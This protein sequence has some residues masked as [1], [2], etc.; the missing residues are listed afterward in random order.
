MLVLSRREN[1][2]IVFPALG[3][4]VEVMKIGRTRASIGIRAP[5]GI[6]VLRHELAGENEHRPSSDALVESIRQRIALEFEDQIAAAAEKLQTAQ[7]D[8]AA[9]NTERA[10]AILGQAITDLTPLRHETQSDR[11]ESKE[12]A[13]EKPAGPLAMRKRNVKSKAETV[14]E[15]SA[16]YTTSVV[17]DDRAAK[18]IHTSGNHTVRK[19]WVLL[20]APS[21]E[22]R[23]VSRS[24]LGRGGFDVD[25]IDDPLAEFYELPRHGTFSVTIAIN[26]LRHCYQNEG[27][28]HSAEFSSH[29]AQLTSVS[30]TSVR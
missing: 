30:L 11:D 20:I 21:G 17:A 4:S 16:G 27:E 29:D 10:S 2:R 5:E 18:R 7:H 1:D 8:L 19:N 26:P 22:S 3:I 23:D 24:E 13:S 9:G 14:A 28:R 15:P 6:R 12:R 25:L